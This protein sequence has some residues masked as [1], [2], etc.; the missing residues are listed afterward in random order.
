[1]TV[2]DTLSVFIM[3]FKV[4]TTRVNVFISTNEQSLV[5]SYSTFILNHVSTDTAVC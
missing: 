4:P 5:L 2:L 1:L 3:G